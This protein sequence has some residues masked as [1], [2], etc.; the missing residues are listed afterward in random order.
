MS[1]QGR[2]RL[3]YISESYTTHDRRFLAAAVDNGWNPFWLRC[4]AG[5]RTLEDAPVPNEVEIVDWL[6]SVEPLVESS[7]QRFIEALR[8]TAVSIGPHLVQA[9]PVPTAG[10]VAVSAAVAPVLVTSW[11]SDLLMLTDVPAAE[12]RVR[13]AAALTG[14]STVLVDCQTV[15]MKAISLGAEIE[16]IAIIPYGV[17]LQSFAYSPL[18]IHPG[19]LRLLSLRSLE[20]PYDVATLLRGLARAAQGAGD[21]ITLTIAGSGSQ[22]RSLHE[23]ADVLGISRLV[24][25]RGRVSENEVPLLLRDHD[26]HVSTSLSDGSSISLLQALASGRPSIVTNLPSNREWI[27]PGVTGWVFDPGNAESLADALDRVAAARED[28]QSIAARGR[29]V[30]EDR[31]NWRE[32]SRL[33]ADLYRKTVQ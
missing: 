23:L 17:D 16:K 26:V 7:C 25:W 11:G 28:L 8:Q 1:K 15:A 24:Q 20:L 18:R 12:T 22:E 19:R 3:I 2:R 21:S 31:A 33:I 10:F 30:A 4:D 5:L 13:A 27:S 29:A 9:G 32:N 14:A 6:G